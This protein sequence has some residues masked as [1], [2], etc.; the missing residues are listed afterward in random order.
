MTVHVVHNI[1][2]HAMYMYEPVHE[3]FV[4]SGEK[5][6]FVTTVDNHV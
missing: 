1:S 6:D 5:V 3:Y 2:A 4:T